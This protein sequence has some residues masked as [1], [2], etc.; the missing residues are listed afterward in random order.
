M[1]LI[2]VPSTSYKIATVISTFQLI[3]CRKAVTIRAPTFC[4]Q[5][6]APVLM[7]WPLTDPFASR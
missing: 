7:L 2:F 1:Y 4:P 6:T 3:V 5:A